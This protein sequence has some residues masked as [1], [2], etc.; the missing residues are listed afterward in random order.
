MKT[1]ANEIAYPSKLLQSSKNEKRVLVGGCFDVIHYGHLQ[2][3]K[4]AKREGDILVVAL[5][6]DEF[7]EKRKKRKPIH[8][9]SQRAEM[10]SE[11]GIVDYVVSLPF[12]TTDDEYFD[13]VKKINPSVI[14]VTEGDLMIEKKQSHASRLGT[15]RVVVV[16]PVVWKMSTSNILKSEDK[17]WMKTD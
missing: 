15:T 3:L 16:T 4:A 2:F 17:S 10:L 9:Q 5:E 1:A 13:M 6:S 8:S 11:L 14:A 7:I 12:L